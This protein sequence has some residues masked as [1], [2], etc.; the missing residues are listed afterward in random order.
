MGNDVSLQ[1]SM[2]IDDK[3]TE[4]TAYWSMYGGEGNGTKTK[5]SLFKGESTSEEAFWKRTSPLE[6]AGRVSFMAI[7]V[8]LS[9]PLI[10]LY[11]FL[12]FQNL[13]L[14]RHPNILKFVSAWTKS[15]DYNLAT[16]HA[17]PLSLCLKSHNAIQICLGL[18]SILQAIT[19]LVERAQ[20]RHL[21]L[22]TVSVYVT[23]DG[24]WKLAGF[25]FLYPPAEL[26]ADLLEQSQ[27]HRYQRAVD[28]R[29]EVKT[30]GL[31]LEQFAFAVLCRDIFKMHPQVEAPFLAEFQ[32]YCR[33]QI[34]AAVPGQRPSLS[35]LLEHPYF[36]QEF[37]RIHE[38][39]TQLPVK[40]AFDKQEFF[41][42]LVRKL[43]T[44]DERDVAVHL[45]DLLLSRMVL[46]DETAQTAVTPFVLD[47]KSGEWEE[48]EKFN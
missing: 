36:N 33:T 40:S 29:N 17:K 1:K 6:K 34:E 18:R 44:F 24:T 20:V 38:F 8:G 22:C 31:Q 14:L 28:E 41:T 48:K 23:D 32:D 13:M 16:E 35:H 7:R 9:H 27:R 46:L 12:P 15:G 3:A 43:R 47:P 25:E 11:H 37:V 39:L 42:D 21:N 19:F 2:T 45:G 26:T 5:I 10:S 30:G 4:V